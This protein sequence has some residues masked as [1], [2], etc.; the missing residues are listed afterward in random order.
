MAS[1]ET[2]AASG[3]G[4]WRLLALAIFLTAAMR[5]IVAMLPQAIHVDGAIQYLPE[6]EVYYQKGLSAGLAA[7][8]EM[9][10]F[11]LSTA[12]LT[13]ITHNLELS[14]RI[15]S[16][17]AG[18]LTVVP[19]YFLVRDL[20][21]PKH[22]VV[23]SILFA[24]SPLFVRNSSEVTKESLFGMFFVLGMWLGWRAISRRNLWT[25][26]VAGIVG[27]LAYLTRPDGLDLF[28]VWGI[29][30]GVGFIYYLS[31]DKKQALSR[32]AAAVVIALPT[33]AIGGAY[34]IHVH[35]K[36]G[37]WTVSEKK[38][39]SQMLQGKTNPSS[40]TNLSFAK[41][42]GIFVGRSAV[43]LKEITGELIHEMTP[44][45]LL[46]AILGLIIRGRAV[47]RADD[48]YLLML[49][50]V[51]LAVAY[52]IMMH[53]T[54]FRGATMI[55]SSFSGRH[56]LSLLLA[57]WCWTGWGIVVL[58]RGA[59]WLLAKIEWKVEPG[60]PALTAA[61][62]A[63]VFVGMMPIALQGPHA[64]KLADKPLGEW[65]R[66]HKTPDILIMTNDRRIGYYAGLPVESMVHYPRN[67][68]Q[69]F[70]GAIQ[71]AYAYH[72]T[73]LCLSMSDVA[74]V[75]DKLDAAVQR[76]ELRLVFETSLK[77]NENVALYE[78][79]KPN[80]PPNR[81]LSEPPSP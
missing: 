67:W 46:L 40:K 14:A 49:C 7:S 21:G 54:T 9:P 11:P 53:F 4:N 59:S 42:V 24:C 65:L 44:L 10:L 3:W 6:A 79:T 28:A 80:P 43:S 26:L 23:A 62:V 22:A 13:T 1:E 78:M 81:P 71:R 76:G 41:K 69:K 72:A 36:T 12:L 38:P 50:A 31:R 52:L 33:L 32:L 8:N 70:D 77:K 29:W 18:I 57:L 45:F 74:K 2:R 66:A 47:F 55:D 60:R 20:F 30:L 27:T 34:V 51:Q 35:Q 58:A 37:R 61:L 73:H 63:I 19:L 16:L 5:V 64:D 56:L 17:F 68:Q 39:L 75:K 48:R 25:C 15:I